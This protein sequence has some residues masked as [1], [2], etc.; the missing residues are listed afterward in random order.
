SLRS[1]LI[2]SLLSLLFDL[3]P[4]PLFGAPPS[5]GIP[6]PDALT[7]PLATGFAWPLDGYRASLAD[8]RFG[9][10]VEDR[11]SPYTGATRL[12]DLVGSAGS[13][14]RCI[15]DGVVAYA[16]FLPSW[17]DERLET[18]WNLG[19]LV[20][21]EHRLPD[22]GFVTSVYGRLG[23]G[24]GVR[25]GDLVRRGQQLGVVGGALSEENGVHASGLFFGLHRGRYLQAAP[26]WCR[27]VVEE[28]K[29]YGLPFGPGG[30]SVR[31]AVEVEH[32]GGTWARI[33][34][35]DRDLEGPLSLLVARG[36]P[37]RVPAPTP[38]IGWCRSHGDRATL[39]EWID[40]A[41]W[42]EPRCGSSE[43]A[44]PVADAFELP[45]ADYLS[46][47][48]RR[49]NFG[50]Y[51][52]RR[53]SVFGGSYHLA[54]DVWLPAGTEVHSVAN[55][56]V[57]YSD[58]SPTWKDA[59]GRKHW[60]FGNVIVI[61][62]ELAKPEK[63]LDH[64]CSVYVHLAADRRVRVGDRVGRGQLIGFI[65]ADRSAENGDYPEHLHFGLHRGPYYQIAPSWQ[66]DLIRSAKRVGLPFGP[67]H[68]IVKGA[69]EITR[70]SRT[71]VLVKF[72]D[73]DAEGTLS[74]LVGSTS[75]DYQPVDIM[76]WC[77]GYGRKAEVEEWLRPSVWIAE[78]GTKGAREGLAAGPR[79]RRNSTSE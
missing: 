25:V 56:V 59:A 76:G 64:V 61:E 19:H 21:V 32:S 31:G 18:H 70:T 63:D 73:R 40:P 58:F 4:V 11:D 34:Y 10:I 57:V 16:D 65:G 77:Q 60:N 33:R 3:D 9:T 75:P 20:I 68:A 38:L 37:G 6:S 14:V 78:H 41:P 74:L 52:S 36:E 66:D 28:A 48:H 2:L 24:L 13:P 8:R 72:I 62:H 35:R 51:I 39:P 49:G 67:D 71:E 29:V 17:N 7:V 12:G 46:G 47:L 50:V 15:A 22:G 79:V 26:G 23:D 44:E 54:E 5:S 45:C 1:T 43:S 69:I 27:W 30:T 53:V 42:L 55:G